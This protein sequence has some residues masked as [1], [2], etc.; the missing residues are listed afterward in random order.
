MKSRYVVFPGGGAAGR[1]NRKSEKRNH[2]RQ[3][4]IK[5]P[6]ATNRDRKFLQRVDFAGLFISIIYIIAK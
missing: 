6:I 3:E 4:N 1:K 5:N 2:Q